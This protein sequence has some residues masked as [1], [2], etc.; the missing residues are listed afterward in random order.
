M[1][2]RSVLVALS[3]RTGSAWEK[4]TPCASQLSLTVDQEGAL[5]GDLIPGPQAG[6]HQVQIIAG[7]VL[8][9]GPKCDRGELKTDTTIPMTLCHTPRNG[10][11]AGG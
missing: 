8:K 11:H 7:G 1:N 9:A 4:K 2:H 3:G 5:C 6:T 10:A